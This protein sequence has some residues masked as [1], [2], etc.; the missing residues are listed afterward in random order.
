MKRILA[1]LLFSGLLVGL[2]GCQATPEESMVTQKSTS[3]LVSAALAEPAEGTTLADIRAAAPEQYSYAYEGDGFTVTADNVSV[4]LPEGD[5]ISAYYVEAGKLSQEQADAIYDWFYPDEE[6]YTSEGTAETKSHYEQKILETQQ[7]LALAQDDTSLTEEERAEKVAGYE[8]L[9]ELYQAALQDAPED[10]TYTETSKDATLTEFDDGSGSYL[11]VEAEDSTL[12]IYSMNQ[13]N[14]FASTVTYTTTG[15]GYVSLD[16]LDATSASGESAYINPNRYAVEDMTLTQAGAEAIA[17]E[18]L[19]AIGLDAELYSAEIRAVYLNDSSILAAGGQLEITGYAYYLTYLR[20]VDGVRVASSALSNGLDESEDEAVTWIWEEIEFYVDETG[21][22][23]FEWQTPLAVTEVLS[24]NV[25]IL[26]FAEAA[27][28]FESYAP[29]Q[30]DTANTATEVT[31]VELGL[32]R[33]RDSGS[34]RTGELV[35]AWIF[36]GRQDAVYTS[37]DSET[38]E[39]VPYISTLSRDPNVL[40]AVNAVDGSVINLTAGY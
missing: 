11:D 20:T 36:Y 15:L 34:E 14:S 13:D 7:L 29:L 5:T 1:A 39:T 37:T 40:L 32:I 21:I 17:E 12:S 24:D 19:T 18:F 23:Q 6:A 22:L 26:T 16:S 33:V 35:P 38:G 31:L 4:N 8:Y 10:S 3:S 28:T 30:F 2:T 9:L 25:G 27:E